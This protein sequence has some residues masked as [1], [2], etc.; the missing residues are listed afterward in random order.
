MDK[1]SDGYLSF[2]EFVVWVGRTG[3]INKLFEIRRKQLDRSRRDADE[4]PEKVAD[5]AKLHEAGVLDDAQ[6][7]WRLVV[8][9]SE[10]VEVE[11]LVD[12]QK[13]AV[14]HIRQL[15]AANHARAL[16]QLQERCKKLGYTD[17]DLWTTLAFI[18]EQAPVVVQ[19]HLH[20]LMDFFEKDT[21]YRNQFETGTSHGTLSG[22]TRQGWERNLFGDAYD[23]AA[24]FDRPK[25]GVLNMMNDHRGVRRASQYGESYFILKDVRLRVTCSPK[26]SSGCNAQHL[27]VLDYFAHV[28]LEFNDN[29][30]REVCDVANGKALS[31][32]SSRLDYY[33]EIQIHGEV[34]LAEHIERIVVVKSQKANKKRI[35]AICKQ[36]GWALSWMDDEESD[37]KEMVSPIHKHRVDDEEWREKVKLCHSLSLELDPELTAE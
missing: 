37:L 23:G 32:D 5:R 20:K 26:D 13:K 11:K 16:P 35:K 1:D 36:H 8:P 12:C 25:Y 10:L 18:R 33:K 29:N 17:V 14:R 21:H 6:A 34:K 4:E 15:A 31:A 7:F 9:E 2:D 24:G 30:L 22:S 27:A 19:I 3:G 28:L